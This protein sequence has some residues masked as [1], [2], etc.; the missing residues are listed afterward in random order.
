MRARLVAALAAVGFAAGAAAAQPEGGEPAEPP[1]VALYNAAIGDENGGEILA[2]IARYEELGKEH[3][4]SVVAARALGRLAS[5]YA[6][7]ARYREAAEAF[8]AY[9]TRYPATARASATAT[10][11]SRSSTA[12]SSCSAPSV[13]RPPRRPS[14]PSR[15]CTSGRASPRTRSPTCRRT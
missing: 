1:V 4:K 3:P 8:E 7:T 2:A 10:R 15:R 5:L 14:S 13:P 9:A 11:S 12:T 6:R